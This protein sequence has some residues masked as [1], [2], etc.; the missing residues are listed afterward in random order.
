MAIL[1]DDIEWHARRCCRTVGTAHGQ[2]EVGQFFQGLGSTWEDF[3][4]EIDDYVASG[5]R[6]CV[7]GR[8][9]GRLDGVQTG[10]GSVHAWTI[11]NGVYVRF[12][13]YVDPQP[14]LLAR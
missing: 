4:L 12:D 10:Y 5:D 9:A 13:E 6:A 3:G 7:I 1:A 8:A 14:E 11:N 2:E